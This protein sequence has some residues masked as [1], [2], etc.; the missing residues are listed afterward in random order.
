M[1]SFWRFC[2][3]KPSSAPSFSVSVEVG[4]IMLM[5]LK[6]IESWLGSFSVPQRLYQDN[7]CDLFKSL[8]AKALLYQDKRH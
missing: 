8:K 1:G 2:L 5:K 6:M 7:S 3:E 4:K